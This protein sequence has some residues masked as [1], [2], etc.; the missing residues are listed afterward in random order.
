MH[1]MTKVAVTTALLAG[2]LLEPQVVGAHD[3]HYYGIADGIKGTLTVGTVTKS[4]LVTEVLMAC[5]GTPREETASSV[6][7]P[8]PIL[9]TASNVHG[10]TLGDDGLATVKADIDRFMLSLDDGLVIQASGLTS[11]AESSCDQATLDVKDS[12][13]AT[14]G[15]LSINGQGQAITGEPNQVIDM[16]P[17]GKVVVNEQVFV[18]RQRSG[19]TIGNGVTITALH[20]YVAD[21]NYPIHGDL[22]FAKSKSKVTC[23]S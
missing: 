10:Y 12:G 18:T 23:S 3:V 14:V 8:R 2:G 5:T 15:S 21:P 13:G 9:I 22:S 11:H 7:N 4:V 17:F 20:V 1:R 19:R 16:G 6:A